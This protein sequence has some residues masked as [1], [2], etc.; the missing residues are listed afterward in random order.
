MS[1]VSITLGWDATIKKLTVGGAFAKG[2]SVPVVLSPALTGT[3]VVTVKRSG[4]ELCQDE[5]TDGAGTVDLSTVPVLSLFGGRPLNATTTADI[6][7]FDN[8]GRLLGSGVVTIYNTADVLSVLRVAGAG[9]LSAP[10]ASTM[11]ALTPVKLVAGEFTGCSAADAA[12]YL[13][14]L[15][16]G[17]A[18]GAT[19]SIVTAGVITVANGGLTPLAAYYLAR[20]TPGL[21]VT[22][23]AGYNVRLVGR[24][25]D[26]NTLV[27]F[28]APVVADLDAVHYL[29]YDEAAGIF[30][31]LAPV[32][33]SAGAEAAGKLVA[34]DAD[35][36]L[37]ASVV[38]DVSGDAVT[39]IKALFAGLADLD[40]ADGFEIEAR[41]N[42]IVSTLRD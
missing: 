16:E 19:A 25:I 10:L 36:L 32:V 12:Q 24:A 15:R 27:L 9:M 33:V 5:I 40:D 37:D 11:T 20:N 3:Q 18:S 22:P 42:L 17:A 4:V 38:P 39:A 34:L 30:R 26:A 31:A 2:E 29:V 35:G 23:P 7:V 14:L 41:L 13:G 21:T 6:Q 28:D 1:I 8:T